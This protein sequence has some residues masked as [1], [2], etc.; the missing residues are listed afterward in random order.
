MRTEDQIEASRADGAGSR[1]PVT[2]EGKRNSSRNAIK[3]GWLSSTIVLKSEL[4]ERF[5]EL[6]ND[7][8]EEL[9]PETSIENTLVDTMAAAR[10]RQ[11][12]L[13][14]M[15]KAGMEYQI[16]TQ[17][18]GLG[19]NENSSTR[20]SIAFRTLSD[21]SRSLDL[22]NRYDSHYERRYLRAHRRFLELR[23]RRSGPSPASRLPVRA[24]TPQTPE[25]PPPTPEPVE[26]L[27]TSE[28]RISAKRTQQTEENKANGLNAK[29]TAAGISP[30]S[31]LQ[32][33]PRLACSRPGAPCTPSSSHTCPPS[34]KIPVNLSLMQRNHGRI[35]K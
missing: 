11:L 17:A 25:P 7:L 12:R 30:P 3:D 22:V 24:Q 35:F 6:L 27:P 21:D 14:G 31:A 9:Q 5:L 18:G 20:A 19:R 1:G 29:A 23:D 26:E 15:E 10:W 34:A 16:R 13:W 8:V 28:P 32:I 33:V 2:P 4:E